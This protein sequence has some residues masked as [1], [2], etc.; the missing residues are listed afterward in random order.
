MTDL[1]TAPRLRT[2]LRVVARRGD[3]TAAELADAAQIGLSAARNLLARLRAA[4]LVEIA[5]S[6]AGKRRPWIVYEATAEGHREAA[7][8]EAQRWRALATRPK[9]IQP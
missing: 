4:G 3:T 2:A 5:G 1:R 6:V 7:R 9:E 8:L